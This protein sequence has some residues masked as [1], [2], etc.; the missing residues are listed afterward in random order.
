MGAKFPNLD[1]YT[2]P[3]AGGGLVINIDDLVLYASHTVTPASSMADQGSEAANQIMAA[4]LFLGVA[5]ER[6]VATDIAGTVDVL[7]LWIGDYA[8]ASSTFDIGDMVTFCENLTTNGIFS[9]QVKKTTDPRLAIGRVLV[10][11]GS[12][13]T[14]VRV[15]LFSRVAPPAPTN[16]LGVTGIGASYKIARGVHTQVAAS[17]TVATGLASVVAVIV[18]PA[19]YT[20]NQQW[21]GAS[22]G[23]QAGS[24]AA[25]SFLLNSWKAT[26]HTNDTTP[27]AATVFTDNIAVNWVAI[28]L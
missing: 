28:G 26:N 7:P 22:I 4:P 10:Y 13:T 15:A 20:V 1:H 19:T 17:D 24:P 9:N 21:F 2:A 11:Y 16:A 18:T 5:K 14:L 6:K 23:D 3:Y 25:G 12:A 27:V 8:C